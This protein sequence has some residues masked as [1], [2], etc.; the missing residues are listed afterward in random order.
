[1][2]STTPPLITFGLTHFYVNMPPRARKSRKPRGATKRN[3]GIQESHKDSHT[4]ESHLV[5]IDAFVRCAYPRYRCSTAKNI[6]E[7]Y[8][9]IKEDGVINAWL[10]VIDLPELLESFPTDTRNDFA[11]IGKA[12]MHAESEGGMKEAVHK[13]EIQA[14]Q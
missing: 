7:E 3:G 13:K 14:F 1:M 5:R 10:N 2:S 8:H 6:D 11:H 12:N 9:P 4:T